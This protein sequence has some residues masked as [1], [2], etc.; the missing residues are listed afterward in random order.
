MQNFETQREWE[1][2]WDKPIIFYEVINECRTMSNQQVRKALNYAMSTWDIEIPVSFHP[3]WYNGNPK[4]DIT[5]EFRSKIQDE[6]FAGQ[7]SVLAYAYFPYNNNSYNGKIVFNNEYIWDFQGSGILAKDALAKGWID[8]TANPN[9][10]IKTY[11]IIAVLIHEL[12]HSLGLTHDESGNASGI[13]VMDAFYSGSDR[14]ELSDRDL[15]RIRAKYGIRIFSHW[16]G[17]NRLKKAL[18]K[19]KRRL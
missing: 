1:G 4:P 15:L 12:G 11:S 7:P 8:G 18:Y 19:A 6:V 5:I 17:Y 14:F 2:K 3:A 16:S 13:D 10:V 9:N